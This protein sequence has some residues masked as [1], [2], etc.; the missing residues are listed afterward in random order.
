MQN[1]ST[2]P[3]GFASRRRMS[4]TALL[5]T[6][7]L[8]SAGVAPAQVQ[9]YSCT[10]PGGFGVGLPPAPPLPLASLKTVPN[11]VLPN[12][13]NGPP[14]DDLAPFIANLPAAIQLGKAL[15]W[16]MQAGSDNKTACATCHFQ[17]GADSRT[18]NQLNPGA[19]ASWDTYG[20][21]YP[22]KSTDFPFTLGNPATR[23]VDNIAGSQGVRQS[24]FTGI[25]SKT[26]AEN[27]TAGTDPVFGN[28]RQVTGKNAPSVI[29]AVFNH[30]QFWNGRAQ[31]EFNGV[32]PF[33][34]RNANARVWML[35]SGSSPS[36]IDIH[37][38]D[39]SLA[40]QAVGPALS[41]VEMSASGRT[42]PDLGRKL[43]PAKPLALQKVDPADSVLGALADTAGKGLKTTYTAMIQKA[44][45]PK[46]W[47][48]SKRMP[49][50]SY[51][52]MEANFSLYWGLAVMVYEATLISDNSPMDQYLASRIFQV[53]PRTGAIVFDAVT[54]LPILLSDNPALLDPLV[55][56]LAPDATAAGL[57]L[58]RQ[59]L[60]NGLALFERP[61]PPP[62]DPQRLPLAAGSPAGTGSFPLANTNFGFD[63]IACH[64]GAETTSASIRNLVGG[65][66]EAG[67]AALRAA[68]FDLRMERM[69][70]RADWGDTGPLTVVPLAINT[71][72]E[73]PAG[74]TQ[75][76]FDSARYLVNVTGMPGPPYTQPYAVPFNLPV[77]T[78]D[79]G[80]Y[81][82]GL[83]PSAEDPGLG[84]ADAF[85]RPLSWT[86]LFQSSG[87]QVKVPGNGLPCTGMNTGTP[88]PNQVLNAQGVPL[89]SGTLSPSEATDVGGTFKVPALRNIEFS[90]PYFH[91]GGK[92]TLA[93]VIDFYD[94]G[95][96]FGRSTNPSKA[97]AI[98][99]LNLRPDQAKSLVAFLLSLSDER[100]RLQQ[101]P[102]DHP[103]LPVPNGANPDGTDI[104][105]LIPA[106]GAGGSQTPLSR[107]L[108]LNPFLP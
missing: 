26:N 84:G 4:G 59:D 19:N 47:N 34:G 18:Q 71:T 95:G 93:Q 33:G 72:T 80:W 85:G 78:Y 96:N 24:A 66:L 104:V 11:P 63:C 74:A 76:A 98:V 67:D 68:G 13:P 105:K 40:S 3:K 56:R 81:D 22:L 100:V 54:G 31:P 38:T 106:V 14:R 91:T 58:S 42:F 15:F 99:P 41:P 77:V 7:A 36:L 86:A 28:L 65:G 39:A 8:F 2:W 64:I 5:C 43:L 44:F 21:N 103:E 50:G 20:V 62:P 29:N 46:W 17:A 75:I 35:G 101:A 57:T 23:N 12:G 61:A 82:V 79:V 25:D 94:D 97:P 51:S 55:S 107:F 16:D 88:F 87:A 10:A 37:I 27:T 102:F 1:Q 73:A 69:F 83:R 92:A 45:Q 70:S 48:Y 60:L 9:T 52:M 108:G 90:G 53:D 30:R 49:S 89:L 32:D 6:A